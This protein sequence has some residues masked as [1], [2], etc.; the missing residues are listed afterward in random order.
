MNRCHIWPKIDLSGVSS[1]V[2]EHFTVSGGDRTVAS[3][4]VR[5]RRTSG[6]SPLIITLETGAGVLL[7]AVSIPSS[8]I[9]ISAPGGDNGGALSAAAI[10]SMKEYRNVPLD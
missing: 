7:E 1:M 9:P 3:A 8:S 2:R 5:L 10:M 6:T 4:H